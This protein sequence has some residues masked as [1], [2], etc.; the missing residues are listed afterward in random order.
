MFFVCFMVA[1]YV[2]WLSGRLLE[3]LCLLEVLQHLYNECFAVST[4]G[5]S[6]LRSQLHRTGVIVDVSACLRMKLLSTVVTISII[7][8]L[9]RDG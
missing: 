4:N 9:S 7:I 3:T 6:S 8:L 5:A 2:F 1:L